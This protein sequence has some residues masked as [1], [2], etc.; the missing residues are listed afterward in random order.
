MK[1]NGYKIQVY[2]RGCKDDIKERRES[3]NATIKIIRKL[4]LELTTGDSYRTALES[5]MT[6]SWTKTNLSP[7]QFHR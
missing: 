2:K 6:A 4:S 7:Q 1:R 3:A 5:T